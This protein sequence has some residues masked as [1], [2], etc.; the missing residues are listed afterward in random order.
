MSLVSQATGLDCS[1]D[2]RH[3]GI[4]SSAVS[5]LNPAGRCDEFSFA[6]DLHWIVCLTADTMSI[7]SSA[8]SALN[9]AGRC[10][11]FSFASDQIGL[12]V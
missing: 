9:P 10:D 5:G 11:E 3:E 6:S 12:F 1:F 4:S 2:R 8:V 7:S